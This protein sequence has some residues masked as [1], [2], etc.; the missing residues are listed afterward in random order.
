MN[1]K[2]ITTITVSDTNG[3]LIDKIVLNGVQNPSNVISGAL[4]RAG[5]W[6]CGECNEWF[7]TEPNQ[8]G[9]DLYCRRCFEE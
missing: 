5:L 6:N 7:T 3:I 9:M 4:E 8:R 1:T 2:N